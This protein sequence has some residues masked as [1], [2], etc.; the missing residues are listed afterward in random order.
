MEFINPLKAK[1]PIVIRITSLMGIWLVIL[2]FL[3]FPRFGI[4]L[5]FEDV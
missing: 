3:V 2:N 4:N 1:Y 5:E